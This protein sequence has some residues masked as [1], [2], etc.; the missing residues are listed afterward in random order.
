MRAKRYHR[1]MPKTASKRELRDALLQ[2][3]RENRDAVRDL[4]AEVME[5]VSL[6]N[7]MREGRKYDG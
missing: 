1:A 2:S 4:L 7:A 5:D 6:A 3:L